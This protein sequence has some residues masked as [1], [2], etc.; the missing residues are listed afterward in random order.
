[1]RQAAGPRAGIENRG[2]TSPSLRDLRDSLIEE[3]TSPDGFVPLVFPCPAGGV[4]A[5]PRNGGPAAFRFVF[6]PV[7]NI[8]SPAQ[9]QNG[10]QIRFAT[11][12]F[13]LA[14]SEENEPFPYSVVY[15]SFIL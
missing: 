1:M 2:I 5:S 15:Q 10:L 11:R 6:D 8:F 7:P 3:L 4:P 9:I 12:F 13:F 14:E